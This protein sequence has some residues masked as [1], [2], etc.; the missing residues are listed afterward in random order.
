MTRLLG[1]GT[2]VI[3]TG[4]G[5]FAELPEPLAV[6]V[7][8]GCTPADLAAAIEGAAAHAPDATA[9][10]TAIAPFAI[11]GLHARLAGILTTPTAADVRASA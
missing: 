11:D 2:P 6:G 7:A 3:V 8:A 5:S 10:R 4:E 1:F 9:C